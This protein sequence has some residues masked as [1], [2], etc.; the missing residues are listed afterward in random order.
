VDAEWEDQFKELEL[1]MQT[2]TLPCAAVTAWVRALL[3]GITTKR[4]IRCG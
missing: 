2:A 1:K 3:N 4:T